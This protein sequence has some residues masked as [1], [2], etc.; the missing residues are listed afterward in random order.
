MKTICHRICFVNTL[1]RAYPYFLKPQM[2]ALRARGAAVDFISSADPEFTRRFPACYRHHVVPM[3][4]GADVWRTLYLIGLFYRIF[5]RERYDLVQY[6]G[7]NAAFYA[8]VAA[9]LAGI[10]VRLY[11]QWG[12][13]YVGFEGFRRRIF[14]L[15]ERLTCACSTRIEPDSASNLEF[16]VC[17]R[18]Y[19]RE[20]G[21][22]IGNGSACGVDLTRFDIQKRAEWRKEKRAECGIPLHAPVIGFVGAL[23]R[24]KGTNELIAAFQGLA[25]RHPDLWLLLVGDVELYSTV[26][27]SLR[28]WAEHNPRV[29]FV[30]PSPDVP[31]WLAALDLF[32]FPSYREGFG[33][34]VIE[35]AAMGVPAVVS[36]IPGP[37]DAIIPEVTGCVVP[38]RNAVRLA[39]AVAALLADRPRLAA[40]ADAAL[41][42]VRRH[43]EQQDLMRQFCE[44]KWHLLNESS[45]VS[46]D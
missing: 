1:P 44:D 32:V 18:L 26:D 19:P 4:R 30:P 23:R 43:F 40:L 11:A 42:H 31:R 8:S 34:V 27:V 16:S 13:R 35:A 25:D 39:E 22:V 37:I 21:R 36:D 28:E 5:R 7:P 6:S 46:H 12:I 17:E 38:V 24:D 2:E 20:K 14:K 45:V 29:V 3:R 10:P 41:K 15:I 33:S 9:K